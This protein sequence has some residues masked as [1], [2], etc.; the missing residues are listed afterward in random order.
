M[1]TTS[2]NYLLKLAKN[3]RRD[4]FSLGSIAFATII[5]SASAFLVNV[6]VAKSLG[7]EGFGIFSLAFS[8]ASLTEIIGNFGFNLAVIRLFNK[9]KRE[10]EKQNLVFAVCLSFNFLFFV[11]LILFAIPLGK[12][13]TRALYLEASFSILFT[14]SF[15]TGGLLL[16]WIFLQAYLQAKQSFKLLTKYI[17]SFAALRLIFLLILLVFPPSKPFS[18]FLATYTFPL[19]ILILLLVVPQGYKLLPIVF[20]KSRCSL[21]IFREI[22]NY[23]KWVALSSVSYIA[24]PHV[25]RFVLARETSL[26]EVGIFSAG[27]TF[28]MVFSTLNT[29]IR[30]VLFPKVTALESSKEMVEYLK[31]IKF[32]M[33]FFISFSMVSIIFLGFFQRV[34]LGER[35]IASLPVFLVSASALS[36]VLFLSLGTML[37]HTMMRPEMEALIEL[38]RLFL[39]FLLSYF[40]AKNGALSVTIVYSIVLLGGTIIKLVIVRRWLRG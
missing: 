24:L 14:I 9:Y 31:K 28:T 37:I 19:F 5:N 4:L 35:Y 16:F 32:L 26:E 25:V 27:M 29:S 40:I 13:L 10:P 17:L 20:H 7:A 1:S 39:V 8:I 15:I 38:I 12:I 34:L 6:F 11:F 2:F 18:W 36:I 21:E 22:I 3:S 33:P 23:S 30:A